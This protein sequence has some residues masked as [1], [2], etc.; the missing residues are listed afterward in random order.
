MEFGTREDGRVSLVSVG[1]DR[2]LVEYNLPDSNQVSVDRLLYTFHMREPLAS[3]TPKS[4]SCLDTTTG[5]WR[6]VAE[7]S[8]GAGSWI[9]GVLN[10]C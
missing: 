8:V 2:C 9:C 1:E 6:R 4:M 5:T 3:L 7:S 10:N